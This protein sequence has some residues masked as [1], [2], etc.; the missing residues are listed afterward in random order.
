VNAI[1]T[2]TQL[3]RLAPLLIVAAG[4][5]L[6]P[7]LVHRFFPDELRTTMFELR[8]APASL[9]PVE[10]QDETGRKI[11]LDRFHGR[12]V[13]LNFWATWCPPCRAEMPSLN[14][15]AAHFPATE[16]SIVP[17]SV[18]VAGVV[19]AR[20]YYSELRLD[21][22]PLYVDPSM[23]AM[24]AVAVVGIPTTLLLDREGRE[25]GRLVGAAQ[26]D[27]PAIIEGLAKVLA[28]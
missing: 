23:G 19:A 4:F 15:L 16:L 12:F 11:A 3:R 17:V 10:F 1:M 26:W 25:I 8:A 22:L 6:V 5:I 18:D 27:S 13:L 14:S 2:V 21:R 24:H 20:G 7:M 9:A 28:R